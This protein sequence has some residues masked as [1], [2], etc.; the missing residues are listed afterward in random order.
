MNLFGIELTPGH[1]I[2]GAILVLLYDATFTWPIPND[3]AT[4]WF[5]RVQG[6]L[7]LAIYT[8]ILG[9]VALFVYMP[10]PWNIVFV[11]SIIA[12]A[13]FVYMWLK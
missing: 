8:G 10:L 3:W 2:I 1:F 5:A 9:L 12:C 6:W 13:F 7:K 11:L 4:W